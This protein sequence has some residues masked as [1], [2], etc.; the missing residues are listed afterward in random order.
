MKLIESLNGKGRLGVPRSAEELMSVMQISCNIPPK[1]DAFETKEGLLEH[2]LILQMRSALSSA[3]Y[4][5]NPES[6]L[7]RNTTN[8][9]AD[10]LYSQEL[11]AR[12][13][14]AFLIR[15]I[16]LRTRKK[17]ESLVQDMLFPS[18]SQQTGE[19]A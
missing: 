2:N 19:L 16:G 15:K 1:K 6:R 3:F 5:N 17:V 18:N 12:C 9:A 13:T 14:P 11:L 4:G 10:L 7:D 8:L